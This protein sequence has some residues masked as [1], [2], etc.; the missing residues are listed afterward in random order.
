MIWIPSLKLTWHLKIHHWKRRFLFETIIFGC[1]VSFREGRSRYNFKHPFFREMLTQKSATSGGGKGRAWWDWMHDLSA[2]S[3]LSQ[4]VF[5]VV[6]CLQWRIYWMFLVF[7]HPAPPPHQNPTKKHVK[8]NLLRFGP[9]KN[10]YQQTTHWHGI[11]H[12][13]SLVGGWTNPSEKYARQNG[14]LPQIGVKIQNI[15]NHHPG[16]LFS[17]TKTHGVPRCYNPCVDQSSSTVAVPKCVNHPGWREN[18][19]F[20]NLSR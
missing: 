13:F 11:A 12:L 2:F 8:L 20:A 19:T 15:W 3:S 7:S 16:F 4:G 17:V 14:N 18:I 9:P 6:F 1:Y 5:P 10:H